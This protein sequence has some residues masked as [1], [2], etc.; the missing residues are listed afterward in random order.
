MRKLIDIQSY[1]PH[2]APMLMVDHILEITKEN[3]ETIFCITRDNIFV[4]N[5]Q[6][7]ETGLI[8]NAAQT[9]SSIVAKGYLFDDED[10]LIDGVTVEGFICAIKTIKI[11]MLPLVDD[12]IITKAHLV[13]S[14]P[15]DDYTLCTVKCTTFKNDEL[16]LEGE[17]NLLIREIAVV[18]TEQAT[19]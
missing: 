7:T 1:L 10:Q 12:V 14:F 6:F 18:S 2:R 16:L 8:E 9:C 19:S 17:I 4:D 3:V 11:H 5:A 15:I 13:S